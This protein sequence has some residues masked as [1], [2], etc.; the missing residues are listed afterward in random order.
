MKIKLEANNE[1]HRLISSLFHCHVVSVGADYK[2]MVED[3]NTYITD[4]NIWIHHIL[5]DEITIDLSVTKMDLRM[6]LGTD[7]QFDII[8]DDDEKYTCANLT[9]INLLDDDIAEYNFGEIEGIS[10]IDIELCETWL[11]T[12]GV[13]MNGSMPPQTPYDVMSYWYDV[14][15]NKEI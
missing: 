12:T 10:E 9:Q 1:I 8:V 14:N 2:F 3:E 13:R 7:I 6:A 11:C 5:R 15:R 4:D